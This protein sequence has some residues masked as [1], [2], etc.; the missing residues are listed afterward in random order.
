MK[1]FNRKLLLRKISS[2]SEDRAFPG[3]PG[4]PDEPRVC[5]RLCGCHEDSSVGCSWAGWQV[6][7]GLHT[8][9]MK[10]CPSTF[11]GPWESGGSALK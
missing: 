11:F 3:V 9:S 10:P 2:F 4:S 7:E 8:G 1:N 6:N 5:R